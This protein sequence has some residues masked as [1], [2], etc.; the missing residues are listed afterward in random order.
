ME[1]NLESYLAQH[2]HFIAKTLMAE[3]EPLQARN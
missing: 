3:I 2:S 1:K